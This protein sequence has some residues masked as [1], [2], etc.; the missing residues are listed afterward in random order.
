MQ[1]NSLNFK[2]IK[3]KWKLKELFS[4]K[5]NDQTAFEFPRKNMH[6]KKNDFQH[7]FLLHKYWVYIPWL[8]QN[9]QTWAICK[10]QIAANQ[11]CWKQLHEALILHQTAKSF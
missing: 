10:Q 8:C 7:V 3:N 2:Q 1:K 11:L 6:S 9:M 5:G 4:V